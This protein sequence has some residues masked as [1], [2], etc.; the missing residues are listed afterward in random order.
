MCIEMIS[1]GNE[2]VLNINKI[3]DDNN[4]NNNNEIASPMLIV[5][6][7]NNLCSKHIINIAT[8]NVCNQLNLPH[9]PHSNIH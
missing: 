5:A 2:F 6:I 7:H 9:T 8:L 1:N 4:N 3:S